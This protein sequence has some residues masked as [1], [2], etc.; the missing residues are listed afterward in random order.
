M[1]NAQLGVDCFNITNITFKN[2]QTLKDVILQQLKNDILTT[3]TTK[4][5]NVC[6]VKINQDIVKCAK[7][8][9]KTL[10]ISKIS[11]TL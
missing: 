5:L 1:G 10:D 8:V 3:E 11:D 4:L 9:A 7:M 2:F 6:L